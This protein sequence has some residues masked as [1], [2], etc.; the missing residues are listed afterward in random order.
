MLSYI[1]HTQRGPVAWLKQFLLGQ[2]PEA[3]QR[4]RIELLWLAARFGISLES[5]YLKS[6]D[7]LHVAP[8]LYK[9][10][11]LIFEGRK[12]GA[13]NLVETGTWNGDTVAACLPHFQRLYSIELQ[14]KTHLKAKKRLAGQS[15]VKLLLGD[16]AK[17]LADIVLELQG[18]TLFWLDGHMDA[19]E[20]VTHNPIY[21]EL[22][23]ILPLKIKKVILIDDARLFVGK[24]GYPTR[25]E[26]KAFIHKHDPSL[27][28]A[29]QGDIIRVH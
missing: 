10:L 24:Y 6:K 4:M 27:A 13:V 29:I 2:A 26:L 3:A 21:K 11:R 18:P 25:D 19:I 16:S 20:G 12:M 22:E 17:R 14:K 28:F 5:F 8:A 1:I 15:K 23:H 9:R 7:P